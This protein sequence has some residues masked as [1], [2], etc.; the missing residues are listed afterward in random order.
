MEKLSKHGADDTRVCQQEP[1]LCIKLT[2]KG[3]ELDK[4]KSRVRQ[5]ECE[6]A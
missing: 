3:G 2:R 1:R 5:R 6:D 4:K